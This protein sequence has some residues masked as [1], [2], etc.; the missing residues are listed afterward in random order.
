M[1]SILCIFSDISIPLIGKKIYPRPKIK[2][3]LFAIAYLPTLLLPTQLFFL[4]FQKY[5]FFF[6]FLAVSIFQFHSEILKLYK[7]TRKN[8]H[9]NSF[10]PSLFIFVSFLMAALFIYFSM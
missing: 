4:L 8:P 3:D 9:M 6:F 10:Y 1:I 7:L 5:F 2:F